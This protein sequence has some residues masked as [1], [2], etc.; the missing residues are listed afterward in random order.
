MAYTSDFRL[1]NLIKEIHL[2]IIKKLEKENIKIFPELRIFDESNEDSILFEKGGLTFT[3]PNTNIKFGSNDAAWI[4]KNKPLIVVE[5]TFGTERG[6]FGDGQLNRFSHSAG[7]AINGYTGLTILP[8]VGESYSK[9][10]QKLFTN[11]DN[12]KIKY[13][14]LHK[15]F[16][17][18]AISITEKEN[19]NFL[20]CDVYNKELITDLIVEIFKKKIGLKNEFEKYKSVCIKKMQNQISGFKYADSSNQFLKKVYNEKKKIVSNFSRYYTHNF[21]ALTT[22]EKRDG[23]GL[24]GKNLIESYLCGK[25]KYYSIFIRLSKEDFIN[26]KKRN[27][28]EFSFLSKS[29]YINLKCF[30][31]L[32]FS[33]DELKKKIINIRNINLFKNRQNELMKRIKNDFYNG[34]IRIKD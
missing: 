15:G 21:A 8:F 30:D 14:N 11:N 2:N 5:G 33:D 13:A 1:K 19:G 34:K 6:Q 17:L 7:V 4:Y 25:E 23:H 29:K 9:D 16:V 22:S 27:Q 32:I 12:I 31:D 18:G 20:I 3:Y 10:G 26:L 24:F 28:K